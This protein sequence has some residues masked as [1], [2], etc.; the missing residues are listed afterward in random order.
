LTSPTDPVGRFQLAMHG[1]GDA[2]L[3]DTVTGATWSL[4]RDPDTLV[5][6]WHEL[7]EREPRQ[8]PSASHWPWR[9]RARSSTQDTQEPAAGERAS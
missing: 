2:L 7:P 6:G 9:S 5:L 1:R 8:F 4:A 3:L